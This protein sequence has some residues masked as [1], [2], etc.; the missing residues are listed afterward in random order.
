MPLIPGSWPPYHGLQREREHDETRT[1]RSERRDAD[2]TR[3][4]GF[5][6]GLSFSLLYWLCPGDS[7]RAGGTACWLEGEHVGDKL[8]K[9]ANTDRGR[10]GFW[11]EVLYDAD[12][13]K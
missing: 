2:F 4:L 3:I 6:L 7:H 12:V 9:E 10:Q 1:S 13:L 5:I 8:D 11:C